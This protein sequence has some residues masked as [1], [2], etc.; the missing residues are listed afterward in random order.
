[1][2]LREGGYVRKRKQNKDP[3]G[4]LPKERYPVE[5]RVLK[6]AA[7]FLGKELLPLLGVEGKLRRAAP[8]EA[9]FL[10]SIMRWRTGPGN[11]WNLRA[12]AFQQRICGVFVPVRL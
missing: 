4:S 7:W 6:D 12:T 9:V 11:I 5:D 2:S 3:E 8:T 1:M 10:I